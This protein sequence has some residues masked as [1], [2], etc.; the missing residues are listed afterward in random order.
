VGVR[1]LLYLV[2]PSISDFYKSALELLKGADG[3]TEAHILAH[4]S[5]IKYVTDKEHLRFLIQPKLEIDGF[6]LEGISNSD[7]RGG[8]K[9]ELVSMGMFYTS[10]VLGSN[11]NLKEG[12]AVLRFHANIVF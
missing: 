12:K 3:A 4:L 10:V 7:Y 9:F 5:T 11:I 2:K 1:M 6:S 8:Q